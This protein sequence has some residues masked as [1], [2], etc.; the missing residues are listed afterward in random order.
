VIK[1]IYLIK[2][3]WNYSFDQKKQA[4][5]EQVQKDEKAKYNQFQDMFKDAQQAFNNRPSSVR[6][7]KKTAD[8]YQLGPSA[9]K[10]GLSTRGGFRTGTPQK[11]ATN[12][13]NRRTA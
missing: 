5:D 3:G 6:P 12:A 2:A 1:A 8:Q 4:Q 9:R 11:G 10:L 13:R 7:G